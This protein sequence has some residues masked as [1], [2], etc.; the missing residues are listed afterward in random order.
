MKVLIT[1]PPMLRRMDDFIHHFV[2]RGIEVALPDVV[3]TL[4]V[5]ELKEMVPLYDGWIIGDDPANREVLEC[6][7]RG[8]LRSAIK[9]GA[10]VDNVDFEAAADLGLPVQNTPGMFGNEV[11]DVALAYVIGLAR[12]LYWIDREVR[13]GRWS[14]PAGVSLAGRK[15]ALVGLGYIGKQVARRLLVCGMEVVAYDPFLQEEADFEIRSWPDGIEDADFLV[16]TCALTDTNRH[17]VDADVLKH[18]KTGL[19]VVNVARGPL[20]HEEALCNALVSGQ[21]HSAALDVFEIEPLGKESPL[22]S[23]E[24]C[25]LGT[26]NGSNT[27]DAVRRTSELA[28]TMLFEQLEAIA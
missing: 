7:V 25:I 6:G 1:C 15:A 4:S 5:S 2:E 12:E 19:R 28:I 21:V 18:C 20:I 17:M 13:S 27:V 10:G 16:L 22:R 14:K 9:W 11:A 8:R 24:R 26:H 3:Q 23:F